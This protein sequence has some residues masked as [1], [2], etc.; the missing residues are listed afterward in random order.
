MEYE[1]ETFHE[2]SKGLLHESR[3]EQ[4][5]R[6][7]LLVPRTVYTTEE[8]RE[9][10]SARSCDAAPSRA[11]IKTSSLEADTLHEAKQTSKRKCVNWAGAR[12]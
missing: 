9:D 3:Y 11:S 4:E 12:S 7:H 10:Q 2:I 6:F 1:H 8:L 5:E